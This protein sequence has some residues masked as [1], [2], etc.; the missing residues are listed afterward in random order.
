M[1]AL[2]AVVFEQVQ[3]DLAVRS[4]AQPV[5]PGFQLSL[6]CLVAVELAVDDG[7]SSLAIGWS[8]IVRSMML[9]RA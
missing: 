2:N 5:S 8:P 3:R 1:E 7:P 6:D 9:R 4:R